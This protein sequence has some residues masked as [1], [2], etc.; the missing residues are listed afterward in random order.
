VALSIL[1]QHSLRNSFPLLLPL[2]FAQKDDLI[3]E[4]DAEEMENQTTEYKIRE[5][6]LVAEGFAEFAL[7]RWVGLDA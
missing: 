5:R 6:A 2:L 3:D 7:V 1:S 4:I